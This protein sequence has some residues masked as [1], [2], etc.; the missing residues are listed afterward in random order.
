MLCSV[1][2]K[3]QFIFG[4]IHKWFTRSTDI[5]DSDYVLRAR[6]VFADGEYMMSVRPEPVE[7]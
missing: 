2:Q 7:G 5:G 6:T 4:N 3:M 1:R